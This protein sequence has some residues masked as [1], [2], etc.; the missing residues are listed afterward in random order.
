MNR[1]I[2]NIYKK[3]DEADIKPQMDA[4]AFLLKAYEDNKEIDIDEIG[5]GLFG[6]DSEKKSAFDEK[7]ERHDMQCDK[8]KIENEATLKKLGKQVLTTGSG[9]EISIPMDVY[10][11]ADVEIRQNSYG[12][13]EIII[14]NVDSLSLR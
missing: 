6:G 9:I 5:V 10:N 11:R 12:E 2:T 1:T 13:D 4:K 8:I 3:C 14:H 7:I